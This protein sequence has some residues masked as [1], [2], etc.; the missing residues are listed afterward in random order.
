MMSPFASVAKALRRG[1]QAALNH[2]LL[3]VAMFVPLGFIYPMIYPE[4]LAKVIRVLP[5]G[6]LCAIAIESTQLLLRMGQCD[7]DDIIANTLGA[8]IG[9][10]C[11]RL[12][13]KIRLRNDEDEE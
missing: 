5:M 11:Y 3:N 12:F 2:M 13:Y 10:V 1:D 4:K 9:A 8:V 6:L 7:I